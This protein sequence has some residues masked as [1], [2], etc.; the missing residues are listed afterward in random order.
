MLQQNQNQN[1]KYIQSAG[2]IWI[3]QINA[4]VLCTERIVPVLM[5]TGV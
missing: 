5:L 2:C 1:W 4:Y 3:N